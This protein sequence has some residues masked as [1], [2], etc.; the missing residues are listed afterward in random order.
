[1]SSSGRSA[2]AAPWTHSRLV[3]TG[4]SSHRAAGCAPPSNQGSWYP[5]PPPVGAK[6]SI[7]KG[8][9]IRPADKRHS[10]PAMTGVQRQRDPPHNNRGFGPRA[11]GME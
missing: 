10:A 1:M 5:R 6:P 4:P 7:A 11:A 3:G 9:A 2:N 8:S